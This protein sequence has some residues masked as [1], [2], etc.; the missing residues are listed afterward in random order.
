MNID[1]NDEIVCVEFYHGVTKYKNWGDA[2]VAGLNTL[3]VRDAAGNE[4]KVT[5]TII[6]V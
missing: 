6:I 3:V 4:T 5:I 2:V 1:D